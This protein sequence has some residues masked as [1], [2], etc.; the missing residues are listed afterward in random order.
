M[1]PFQCSQSLYKV[2]R[3]QGASLLLFSI[4]C[5]AVSLKGS[6]RFGL[7]DEII[8][9][10]LCQE[11][12]HLGRL[13]HETA[14]ENESSSVLF[15]FSFAWF[16]FLSFHHEPA[17]GHLS[18]QGVDEKVDFCFSERRL[19]DLSDQSVAGDSAWPLEAAGRGDAARGMQV[20]MGHSA[21]RL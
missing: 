18:K 17:C 12:P 15:S 4:V 11:R 20:D 6:V 3:F 21:S 14:G 5:D 13:F 8:A 2:R 9:T 7:R 10:S 16:C 1:F 19:L